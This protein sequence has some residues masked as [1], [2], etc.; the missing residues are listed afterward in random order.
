MKMTET[1]DKA[2]DELI[3]GIVSVLANRIA[4]THVFRAEKQTIGGTRAY[5][6]VRNMSGE[7]EDAVEDICE[8]ISEKLED[9]LYAILT[10]TVHATKPENTI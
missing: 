7:W 8:A 2:I 5:R 10:N 9:R 3:E 6:A 1:D 4:Q